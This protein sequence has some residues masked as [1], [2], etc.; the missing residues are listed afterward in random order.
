MAAPASRGSNLARGFIVGLR[1]W[2]VRALS[3]VL[4][5]RIIRCGTQWV[6][7]VIEGALVAF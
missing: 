6:A 1:L 7:I 4:K 3:G 2:W 5:P